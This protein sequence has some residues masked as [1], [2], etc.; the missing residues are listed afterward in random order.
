M[1][2]NSIYGNTFKLQSQNNLINI[3]DF[4]IKL[5]FKIQNTGVKKRKIIL[6]K[7]INKREMNSNLKS[8]ENQRNKEF[9]KKYDLIPNKKKESL[10][11]RKNSA[12]NIF[13]LRKRKVIKEDDKNE[14]LINRREQKSTEIRVTDKNR[15]NDMKYS[16][17]KI[18]KNKSFY[19]INGKKNY[20]VNYLGHQ[21]NLIADV[22]NLSKSRKKIATKFDYEKKF[23]ENYANLR[24]FLG[25]LYYMKNKYKLNKT[26]QQNLILDNSKNNGPSKNEEFKEQ[27]NNLINKLK[28]KTKEV[29]NKK[30]LNLCIVNVCSPIYHFQK[31]IISLTRSLNINHI[32]NNQNNQHNN[33]IHSK[34]PKHIKDFIEKLSNHK[35]INSKIVKSDTKI[36]NNNNQIKINNNTSFIIK[37]YKTQTDFSKD[38]KI[39]NRNI[40]C[41]LT[42]SNSNK[43]EP[44][45]TKRTQSSLARKKSKTDKKENKSNIL[46]NLDYYYKHY[47][48]EREVEKLFKKNMIKNNFDRR[49]CNYETFYYKLNKM[50]YDQLPIYMSHRINWDIVEND[51]LDDSFTDQKQ[52]INFEWKY[53]PN[54]L[55][56]KKY[57][58]NDTTNIKKLCAINLFEK[59]YEIGNKKKMFIHL[60]NYCDRINLN[61]FNYIPFTI[62]I[63]NTRLIDEELQAFQE[64]KSLVDLNTFENISGKKNLDFVLNRKYN[65]QFW[66]ESKLE[67]LK[68]QNIFINKNF[69]S[70]KN[71]WMLK[72]TDL[73]QGKCIEISNSFNEINKKC[74]KIFTGVDKFAKPE[75]MDEDKKNNNDLI[76]NNISE[77]YY[78]PYEF[79]FIQKRKKKIS[80]IY[81]SSELIIQKYLDK[82]LLYRKRKFDIRCFV[83]ADWNLN[84][85]FCREGH[86][87]ASSYIYDINNVNK[88]IHITNHSFQKKS[89]KFEKFETGNE[90][91]YAEF[92]QFLIEEKIPIANFD[93][94][95]NKMKFIVKLSFQAVGS[96]L[97]RTPQVLSFE[98]FGYDFIID[99]EY[100]PWLLE[101]NNN[102]G[103]SISS[104]IIAKLIPRM[105]DDAFRLTIDKIFNTRYSKECFD[106]NKNYKSKFKL[107]GYND[108]ENIFEF[109][110]NVKDEFKSNDEL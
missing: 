53:Y 110:C 92:K 47:I 54:K 21:K 28:T 33:L 105:M 58:Y 20:E 66:F 39:S 78:E 37:K 67:S 59:N 11:K 88:F 102:P 91:S 9:I 8:D 30:S 16:S 62:L 79:D 90:I 13:K 22:P 41:D 65:E 72:P 57:K 97:M 44:K 71:Y 81:I 104:P 27:V 108:N 10:G 18:L 7:S 34:S 73:Y 4:F 56:Y 86:L 87:K 99:N 74:K 93:K 80:N 6:N 48:S 60:I 51:D 64:I 95:I 32:D 40:R 19:S 100:N 24:N 109:L 63:N 70:H 38:N 15:I 5:M 17:Q 76:N 29:N 35:V 45:H 98:L 2:Y 26:L 103:L 96:K 49:F 12:F 89:N 77:S 75:I 43:I 55:Y 85:F 36:N 61:V 42:K 82:P 69:L 1:T 94:I 68:N 14:L 52:F 31:D 50:Y 23:R 46:I 83:L 107:E 101:I 84:I 3:P 25:H 106:K